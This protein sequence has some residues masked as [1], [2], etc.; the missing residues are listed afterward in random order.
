MVNDILDISKFDAK[1]LRLD[2]EFLD[3]AECVRS[4]IDIAESEAARAGIKL[5]PAITA[6]LPQLCGDRKRIQQIL[7]N[8]ISNAIRFAPNG[9]EVRISAFR[10]GDG[11]AF[12]SR[13]TESASPRKIF[14][15]CSNALA[16]MR[17]IST[18]TPKA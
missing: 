15:R 7:I 10:E 13:I 2:D 8:L 11:L 16:N 9:S 12:P 3:I 1:Q 6:D 14:Q 17:P 4:T 5:M 18:E